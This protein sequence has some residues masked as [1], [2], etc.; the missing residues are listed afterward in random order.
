MTIRVHALVVAA[1]LLFAP[2]AGTMTASRCERC[3][4]DCP[5][6]AKRLRCHGRRACPPLPIGLTSGT[7]QHPPSPS[8][9]PSLGAIVIPSHAERPI[10]LAERRADAP[11]RWAGR[12][13]R[14]PLVEPPRPAPALTSQA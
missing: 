1:A 4:P 12:P 3:A 11:R 10:V 2:I 14:P 6:H 13:A 9:M 7:C 8:A 5:M